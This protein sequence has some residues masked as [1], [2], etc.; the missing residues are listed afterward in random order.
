MVVSFGQTN[1]NKNKNRIKRRNLIHIQ[2]YEYEI[3]MNEYVVNTNACT[4]NKTFTW[5]WIWMCRCPWM[6]R[7]ELAMRPHLHRS[8]H[9]AVWSLSL[10]VQGISDVFGNLLS[11]FSV[12][13]TEQ[14]R[15]NLEK[16][17]GWNVAFLNCRAYHF[18]TKL[19]NSKLK[20]ESV[21]RLGG[22]DSRTRV[23]TSKSVLQSL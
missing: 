19:W 11:N 2:N 14:N 23:S 9:I 4:A 20:P 18:L 7:W 13:E 8:L 16:I 22:S 6:S 17:S 3:Y 1:E 10:G 15:K 5:A 21:G 12:S